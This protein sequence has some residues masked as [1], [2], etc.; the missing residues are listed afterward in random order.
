MAGK[1]RRIDPA[2]MGENLKFPVRGGRGGDRGFWFN[3][4]DYGNWHRV[5]FLGPWEDAREPWTGHCC[6]YR[7]V[8]NKPSAWPGLDGSGKNRAIT[9][10]EYHLDTPC[11][12]CDLI[13]YCEKRGQEVKAIAPKVQWLT[14]VVVDNQ[15]KVW[16]ATPVTVIKKLKEL[17]HNTRFGEAIFDPVLGRDMEIIRTGNP[18]DLSSIS[19]EIVH[20][21]PSAIVVPDWESKVQ[22]L[23][24]FVKHYERA[25]VIQVLEA[26][27]GDMLPVRECFREELR[28]IASM[29]T[30]QPG[31]PRRRPP[32]SRRKA[33]ARKT[34]VVKKKPRF[35][36]RSKVSKKGVTKRKVSKRRSR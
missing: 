6:H 2:A 3:W 13:A 29:P 25:L 11:P 32:T 5:R 16:G 1:L 9:C 14:N 20:C 28:E 19:Y 15:V 18:E 17:Y 7:R 26:Q 4:P 27:V 31:P 35:G 33:P 12:V 24:S 23:S 8:G 22:T 30:A 36:P 10:S 34:K 21:D